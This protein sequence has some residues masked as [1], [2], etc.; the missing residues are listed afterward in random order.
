MKT[1]FLAA[2]LLAA[3]LTLH[4]KPKKS[5]YQRPQTTVSGTYKAGPVWREARPLEN[6]PR[7]AWW[8]VFNDA[9]LN[10][11]QLRATA[12]SQQ[13]RVAVARFD[14]A[15]ATARVARS[16]FFPSAALNPTAYHQKTSG[17]IPSAFPLNGMRYEGW[18][19][20]MPVD[21]TWELDL[22]G[23]VRRHYE[24]SVE[25]AMAE[26]AAMQ[27]ALLSL[28]A[29]IAQNYFRLRA[30]DAELVTLR[31][32]V[33]WR[34]Q[35]VTVQKGRVNAGGGSEL[36]LAQAET[37]YAAAQTELAALG[38]QRAQLENAIAILC[39]ADPSS[40][41]IE[42]TGRALPAPPT[43][44]AGLPS[45][46]L[47]RRPDIAQSERLLVAATATLGVAQRAWFPSVKL[48][49]SGGFLSGELSSLFSTE[50]GKWNLGPGVSLPLFSGGKNKANLER[51][52]AAHDEALALYRQSILTALGDVEN[53]LTALDTLRE[54]SA[55][56]ART[57]AAAEKAARL[58]QVRHDAGSSPYLEV[59]EA[60]RTAL[61]VRRA[62]HQLAGQR[63]IATVA[64]IKALGGGWHQ[65]LPVTI[66]QQT[67]DP[68]TK[69]NAEKK[70]GVLKRIFGMR[71]E[72]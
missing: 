70:P 28:H 23:R 2:L 34:K 58:A 14:Q 50:S 18:S 60:N 3:P 72:G 8:S 69:S 33:D 65:S 37:E 10:K 56:Q 4:A 36:E 24:S 35:W 48:I 21:L 49:A 22:W 30:L 25:Q 45:D 26:A 54:Q 6:L 9:T 27:N 59:I 16:N 66:P 68:A 47:E 31:E 53:Q 1:P 20:D 43:V 38:G 51:A 13:L 62:S 55:S 44:P 39:G 11:L 32:A 46:L 64:L 41:R 63:L 19:F 52:R 17:N 40:F 61:T 5:D 67:P 12:E 57:L 71:G 15:R 29:E 7:G 42:A